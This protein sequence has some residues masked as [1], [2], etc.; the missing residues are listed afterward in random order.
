MPGKGKGNR[1]TSLGKKSGKGRR[2]KTSGLTTEGGKGEEMRHMGVEVK[3]EEIREK[4]TAA[5]GNER[6]TVAGLGGGRARS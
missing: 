1:S 4:G 2:E 6:H 5:R 3:M